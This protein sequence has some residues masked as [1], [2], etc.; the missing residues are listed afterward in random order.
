MILYILCIY[1]IG[2]KRVLPEL[3]GYEITRKIIVFN[4]IHFKK[5]AS[6]FT[7]LTVEGYFFPVKAEIPYF[8]NMQLGGPRGDLGMRYFRLK[9][10][11]NQKNSFQRSVRKLK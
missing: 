1:H 2:S 4:Q 5:P 9:Y 10:L 11:E 8:S 7:E 3:R 6:G